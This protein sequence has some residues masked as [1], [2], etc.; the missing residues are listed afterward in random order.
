[1]AWVRPTRCLSTEVE[2][3]M[4]WNNAIVRLLAYY[5]AVLVVFASVTT[6]FPTIIEMQLAERHRLPVGFDTAGEVPERVDPGTGAAAHLEPHVLVPVMLG[7]VGALL[8]ALP[9]SWTYSW[10]RRPKK[11]RRA[12]AQTLI[13]LPVAVALVLFLVKG[14]LAL[15][16]SLAGVVAAIR[17]RT[18]LNNTM[19]AVFTFVA[20][21][22]GL[23]SGIQHLVIAFAASAFFN[24]LMLWMSHRQVGRSPMQ[25]DG[26]T[27][28]PA[29]EHQVPPTEELSIEEASHQQ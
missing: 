6:A 28:R 26:W 7:M 3:Q 13:A 12:L 19:D 18:R 5:T 4:I 22:I 20:I 11:Y 21:G 17:W 16:F 23:A 10:T 9:L 2:K 27:L 14:S 29:M 1:M 25:L 8:L 15:A 24:F